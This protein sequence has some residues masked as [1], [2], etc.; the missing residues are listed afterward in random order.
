MKNPIVTCQYI[1]CGFWGGW[2]SLRGQEPLFAASKRGSYPLKTNRFA[3][4]TRWC[5]YG[6]TL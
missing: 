6:K 1:I 5:G 3:E 4:K 2:G